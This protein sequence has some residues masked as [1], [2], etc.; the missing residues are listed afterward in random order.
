MKIFVSFAV[1]ALAKPKKQEAERVGDDRR[2][3]YVSLADTAKGAFDCWL[4]DVYHVVKGNF[5]VW[6][7]PYQTTPVRGRYRPIMIAAIFAANIS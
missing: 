6:P 5:G 1:S 7:S 2:W 4:R 3:R